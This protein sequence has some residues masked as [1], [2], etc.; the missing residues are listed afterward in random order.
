MSG[1]TL[2]YY[3][4]QSGLKECSILIVDRDHDPNY[5]I[6]F[7]ADEVTPFQPIM[8]GS[9][10]QIAVRYG[11]EQRVCPLKR[12]TLQAFWRA[13]FDAYLH[14][15][16][17]KTP[18]V[19]FLDANV[20]QIADCGDHA[21]VVAGGETITASW[22]FDSR[23]KISS[24]N[25][26]DPNRL[27]MQGLAWEIQT[28]RPG[29]DPKTAILSDFLLQTPEF[30]F[31][32]LL[33]YTETYAL[34]D[35]AFIT[36]YG[37]AVNKTSCEQVLQEYISNRLGISSY[38]VVKS[39]L[40]RIPLSAQRTRR[41][42]RSRIVPIGVHGGM[43]KPTTS[44]AFTRILSDSQRITQSLVERGT[45]HYPDRTPWYYHLADKRMEAIYRNQPQ[46]AQ[47]VMFQMFSAEHGDATLGF[48]DEKNS[49]AENMQLF[50]AVPSPLL[51]KFLLSLLSATN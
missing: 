17:G 35:C 39:C 15:Q 31:I 12:Y 50:K 21:E 42:Q 24:S 5:N 4:A 1:M 36:P 23:L 29:F 25:T 28:D 51:W 8:R 6:S 22:I 14:D 48:L 38:Q 41:D 18:N 20:T 47:Q 44:Y 16:L 49:L 3:L 11:D 13:D 37:S 34:V 9:W 7:W 27:L 26:A 30:D 2:A 40:G 19:Q 46:L 33:P 43:V 10:R 45:P 32:Y